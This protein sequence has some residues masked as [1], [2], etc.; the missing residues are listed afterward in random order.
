M[1]KMMK[2]LEK[3]YFDNKV[4]F[5]FNIKDEKVHL[6]EVFGRDTITSFNL[7]DCNVLFGE[8]IDWEKT[9][10]LVKDDKMEK[11]IV[12]SWEDL[13]V[14]G[15]FIHCINSEFCEKPRIYL[16]EL[17]FQ[18]NKLEDAVK[19]LN[20]LGGNFEYKQVEVIDSLEKWEEFQKIVSKEVIFYNRIDKKFQEFDYMQLSN[21]YSTKEIE[22]KC[23]VYLKI[24]KED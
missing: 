8:P 11:V 1:E 23:N 21:T 2:K 16:K 5:I 10:E 18:T 20:A 22:Q 13:K 12:R 7:Y 19:V 9:L 24:L 17:Y 6:S 3:L 15:E 14:D 4:E